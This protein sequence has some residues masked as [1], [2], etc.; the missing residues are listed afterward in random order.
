MYQN[1]SNISNTTEID[2][3][4]V[5]GLSV[6]ISILMLIAI[7]MCICDMKN[8]TENNDN[9]TDFYQYYTFDNYYY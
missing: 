4:L 5:L 1:I 9:N 8:K 6:L 2:F 7:L 3:N